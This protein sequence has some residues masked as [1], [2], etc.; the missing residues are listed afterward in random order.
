MLQLMMMN[1][2]KVWTAKIS[3]PSHSNIIFNTYNDNFE[4]GKTKEGRF[5]L[6]VKIL[7]P[8][9]EQIREGVL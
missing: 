4:R 8:G 3:H 7:S 2:I 5:L 1:F 9:S 6:F